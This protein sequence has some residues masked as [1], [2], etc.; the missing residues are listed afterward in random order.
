M[1]S[2]FI[3]F[4]FVGK[5]LIF[6]AKK[7]TESNELKGFIGRLFTCELCSGVWSFTILSLLLGENLFTDFFY[8]PLLSELITGGATSLMMHLLTLG[9]KSQFEVIVIE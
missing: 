9:W 4:L 7:F 2:S 1:S 3:I 6:L 8:V 5:L